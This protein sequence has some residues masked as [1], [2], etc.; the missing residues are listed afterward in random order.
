MAAHIS[1]SAAAS[2]ARVSEWREIGKYHALASAHRVRDAIER[3]TKRYPEAAVG[4]ATLLA[5]AA[6]GA[7]NGTILGRAPLR[8]AGIAAVCAYALRAELEERWRIR[9]D[10]LP[11]AR[12]AG[13]ALDARGASSVHEAVVASRGAVGAASGAVTGGLARA[14][15]AGES[16]DAIARDALHCALRF[17]AAAAAKYPEATVGVSTLLVCNAIGATNGTLLGRAPRRALIAALLA[18]WTMRAEL[19]PRWEEPVLTAARTAASAARE[20]VARLGLLRP[21]GR[22]S[23][24]GGAGGAQR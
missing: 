4:G 16:F 20:A 6:I 8:A 24:D 3:D 17:P 13:G 14:S 15:E 1:D 10:L 18:T 7:S 21:E 9:S 22:E 5:C 23:G 11:R 2:S 12:A 19:A